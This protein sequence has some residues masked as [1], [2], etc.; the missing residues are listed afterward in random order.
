[1]SQSRRYCLCCGRGR[2]APVAFY[3]GDGSMSVYRGGRRSAVFESDT[4][5]EC[6]SAGLIEERPGRYLGI[7]S[8]GR[9]AVNQ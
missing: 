2:H 3:P 6:I 9:K 8:E 5:K 7:T 1:M 4:V